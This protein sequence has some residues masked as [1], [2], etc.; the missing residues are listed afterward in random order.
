MKTLSEQIADA[1]STHDIRDVLGLK[2]RERVIVCPLP[3]HQHKHNTPSFSIFWRRGMQ[4]FRCHGSCDLEGDV[5]D[6][7]GYLR[8]PNYD[9]RDPDK[10][11]Q[12]LSLLDDRYS[13]IIPQPEPEVLLR[14]GEWRDYLPPGP[15]VIEYAASRGLNEDTLK[16]YKIGQ[17]GHFMTM[18]CFENG[19]LMGV[20][21]RN[22]W[23]CPPN[24]RFWQLEGSRLGMFNFDEVNL[25]SGKTIFIVKGEIPVMLLNQRGFPYACAPTGGEASGQKT[26]SK[27]MTGLSLSALLVIGDNDGPGYEL[28]L[29]RAKLF[30][31]FLRFPPRKYKDL[32]EWCLDDPWQ[33]Y[34]N[35]K[36]WANETLSNWLM[37]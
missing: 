34:D 25:L 37:R 20:K 7:V 27:W 28:A 32:D 17:Y 8:V 16:K 33:S 12:A 26:I 1:R 21:M 19:I 14:G 35:L 22:M 11:R 13:I 29:K 4:W 3:Q 2:G 30:G 15:E 10:I 31:A 36:F 24:R 9:K 23:Q 6:L 5:I 18:P